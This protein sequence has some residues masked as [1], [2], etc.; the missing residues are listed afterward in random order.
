MRAHTLVWHSQT[1]SWFFTKNYDGSKVVTPA[2]MD[3]R[4]DFYIHN[5]MGHVMDKEKALTGSAGSI[6]YAWDVV[7]EYLHR[8]SFAFFKTWT[9]VYGDMGNSPSYVKKAFEIAYDMLK[10]YQATDK[11]T[12]FYNDYNTYFGVKDTLNLV[13]FINKC[14]TAKICG[15]ILTLL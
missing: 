15:G 14:E 11:V 8:P 2:V 7:N 6:V 5:V 1:P 13:E 12:L 4:L 3:A 10:N 9:S